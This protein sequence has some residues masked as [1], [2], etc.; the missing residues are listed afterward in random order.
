MNFHPAIQ[1]AIFVLICATN[2]DNKATKPVS[3]PNQASSKNR[4]DQL[5]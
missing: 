2:N 3:K 5:D 4:T 1:F